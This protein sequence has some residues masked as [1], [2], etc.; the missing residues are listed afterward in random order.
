MTVEVAMEVDSGT[1]ER[2]PRSSVHQWTP[3]ASLSPSADLHVL[4][5]LPRSGSV[6]DESVGGM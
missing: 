5:A 3:A 1:I 4:T 6:F 2:F